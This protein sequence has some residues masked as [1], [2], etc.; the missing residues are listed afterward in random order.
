L[1]RSFDLSEQVGRHSAAQ[2]LNAEINL[3]YYKPAAAQG[4]DGGNLFL[5]NDYGKEKVGNKPTGRWRSLFSLFIPVQVITP[6]K[7]PE[8]ESNTSENPKFPKTQI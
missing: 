3:I 8:S 7:R 2:L 6:K 5:M 1:E 4:A